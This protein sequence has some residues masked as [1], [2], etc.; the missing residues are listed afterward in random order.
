MIYFRTCAHEIRTPI[1]TVII[2]INV[3]KK[4]IKGTVD[5]KNCYEIMKDI[6]SSCHV[7]VDIVS[8]ML[9]YDKMGEG[10]LFLEKYPIALW[11][12][13]TTTI[14]PFYTQVSR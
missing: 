1:N 13:I 10:K 3:L 12:L 9:T 4:L 5:R 6:R 11:S 7:A 8:D 14:H 2:G